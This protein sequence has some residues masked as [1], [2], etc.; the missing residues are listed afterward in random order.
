MARTIGVWSA[1]HVAVGMIEDGRL[2]GPLRIFPENRDSTGLQGM[3][4]EQIAHCIC[5]QINEVRQGAAIDAV[6]VG[7][8]GL[9]QAG[10]VQESPNLK[11]VK[12]FDLQRALTVELEQANVQAPVLL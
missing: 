6:G 3:P 8:P 7:F 1:E 2:A 11:Q 10:A 12:G 4:S 5:R 9:I